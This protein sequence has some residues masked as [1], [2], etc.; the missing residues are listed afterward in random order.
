MT[1]HWPNKANSFKDENFN[2]QT[3]Y[4]FISLLWFGYSSLTAKYI[5]GMLS[6]SLQI[7]AVFFHMNL[8]KPSNTDTENQFP[9][10]V[11]GIILTNI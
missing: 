4:P 2:F 3:N 10:C 5:Q 9:L 11:G 7:K 6:L 8:P 1:K